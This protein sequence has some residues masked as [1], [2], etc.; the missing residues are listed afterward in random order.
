M[1]ELIQLLKTLIEIPSPNPPGD[2]R[3]IAQ[4]VADWL[5]LVGANVQVLAPLEKPEAQSIVARIGSGAPVLMLHAHIDT[6]PVAD[7][8]RDRWS[9]DPFRAIER[10]GKIYGKGSVDDK[11]PLAAMMCCLSKTRSKTTCSAH[12]SWWLPPKKK[13][14]VNSAQNG[15]WIRVIYQKATLSWS[16]SRPSTGSPPPTRA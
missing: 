9:S 6:V 5:G 2:A 1:T 15:W 10:D 8:E 7:L 4:F 14:A 3:A 16:A 11:A 13:L 12:W